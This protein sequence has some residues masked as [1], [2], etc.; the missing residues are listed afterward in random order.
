MKSRARRASFDWFTAYHLPAVFG[1]AFLFTGNC[2][3]QQDLN[4]ASGESGEFKYIL[5]LD[6]DMIR[7]LM[8]GDS[9]TSKI[10]VHLRDKVTHIQIRY[11]PATTDKPL[12]GAGDPAFQ[13]SGNSILNPQPNANSGDPNS[14][15]RGSGTRI[16]NSTPALNGSRD[17][18]TSS[19][20]TPIG[21]QG[22]QGSSGGSMGDRNRRPSTFGDPNRSGFNVP[23]FPRG[24][25]SG[26]TGGTG[27]GTNE[28]SSIRFPNDDRNQPLR[29]SIDSMPTG[30][31]STNPNLEST[32]RTSPSILDNFRE[33]GNRIA[34]DFVGNANGMQPVEREPN[35][36][37][38]QRRW[39]QRGIDLA[40]PGGLRGAPESGGAG[41]DSVALD[42]NRTPQSTWSIPEGERYDPI[43]FR[44]NELHRREI[45]DSSWPESNLLTTSTRRN[46]TPRGTSSAPDNRT[47]NS[48]A[49]SVPNPVLDNHIKES[50]E[51]QGSGVKSDT[52]TAQTN[53]AMLGLLLSGFLCSVGF[54]LYLLWISRGFY[55]RYR[56][57]ADELRDT[58]TTSI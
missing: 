23:S 43:A 33:R 47:N 45:S 16:D 49:A 20:I 58:F 40:E 48:L 22:G 29:N 46:Q 21:D 3:A 54:N 6:D 14:G 24:S 39:N 32:R 26:T 44:T 37:D 7:A 55:V 30:T 53:N 25:N 9:L 34:N 28:N 35:Y 5:N 36:S 27:F 31:P 57:L 15:F 17:G 56:E 18:G 50:K 13:P 10:P 2:L 42:T 11:Q 4:N 52:P 51:S 1:L 12:G 19:S 38:P 8:K 41:Q